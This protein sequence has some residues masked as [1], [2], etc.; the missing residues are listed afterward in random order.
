MLGSDLAL[1]VAGMSLMSPSTILPAFA[2]YLGAPNVVIGAIPAVMTLGWSLPSLFAAGHTETL[3]RKLPFILRWT[4]WER[5]P[6]PM[7]A[8]AAFFLAVPAPGLT[9]AVLLAMLLGIT[10]TGGLMM[11]AWMDLVGRC[12]PTTVRGRFFAVSHVLGNLGGLAGSVLTAWVLAAVAP[13]ASFGI[14]FVAATVVMMLS[15]WALTLIREPEGEPPAPGRPI[16]EYLAQIPSL[17]RR[18]RNLSWFLTSRV[19]AVMGG[20]AA[21]FFTVYALRVHGAPAWQVGVFTTLMLAGHTGGSLALGWLADHFGHRLVLILGAG[22]MLAANLLA[23]TA[24]TLETFQIVFVA[25]GFHQAS[26]NVSYMNILLDF[27]PVTEERPTYVG[28]GNTAMAPVALLS[29]LAAGLLADAAGF[30]IVFA[31]AAGCGA[32]TLG[33]LLARVREPRRARIQAE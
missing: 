24:S 4:L 20:M 1:F 29:P 18:D 6:F 22:A 25:A 5:I 28:L 31:L 8:L 10:G 15:Y 16:L 23:L 3:A 2:L 17:L 21:G 7:L 27:A 32:I 13:P 11:P 30:G 33:V 12:I 19:C 26:V 14:C 9:L